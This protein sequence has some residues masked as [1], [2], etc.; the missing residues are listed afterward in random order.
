M[1]GGDKGTSGASGTN[2]GAMG[3][4]DPNYAYGASSGGM[5]ADNYSAIV[6]GIQT[7]AS[8]Y[9]AGANTHPEGGLVSGGSS[10][11]TMTSP[12]ASIPASLIPVSSTNDQLMQAI[13][14]LLG[15]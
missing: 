12:S 4:Y 1:G 11:Q 2:A 5:S 15:G 8:Q 6:K 9:A 3:Y 7:G 10:G 13:Q 14:R